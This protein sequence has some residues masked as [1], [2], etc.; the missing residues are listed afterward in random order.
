MALNDRV[1]CLLCGKF[2]GALVSHVTRVHHVTI[3]EYKRR[4]DVCKV[5]SEVTRYRLGRLAVRRGWGRRAW[6]EAQVVCEILQLNERGESLS[7]GSVED[8][9]PKLFKQGRFR[10]GCWE[11]ALRAAGVDPER[12]PNERRSPFTSEG[13]LEVIRNRNRSRQDLN[14]GV[15]E[16]EDSGC[17]Q[18]AIRLFGSWDLALTAAGLDPATIRRMRPFQHWTKESILGEIRRLRQSEQELAA[19]VVRP[20][21]PSLYLAAFT[22]F[23]GWKQALAEAGLRED[24]V[25]LR[26][27]TR[28]TQERAIECIRA[29]QQAGRS[30]RPL[31]VKQRNISLYKAVC[32]LFPGQWRMAL[33]AA[34][35]DPEPILHQMRWSKERI[36][37]VIR[38]RSQAGLPLRGLAL[39]R[40]LPTLQAAGIRWFGSWAAAL[41]FAEV[42]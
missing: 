19:S 31:E 35:I 39:L 11:K 27:R 3:P 33:T 29:E 37:D 1:Q 23:G 20:M 2:Y 36:A 9:H 13:V 32:R 18:A 8:R 15:M 26:F 10:F 40:D 38:T 14:V 42:K 4:F 21:N 7:S 34:G 12:H 28:W 25:Y 17:H 5:M 16:E 6:T 24:E 41:R 22:H 30:L